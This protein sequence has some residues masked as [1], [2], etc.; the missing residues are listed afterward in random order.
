MTKVIL[1][2]NKVLD[3]MAKTHAALSPKTAE[4]AAQVTDMVFV[5]ERIKEYRKIWDIIND[6]VFS[7]SLAIT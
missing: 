3:E 2:Y 4:R 6:K 7:T 5:N 1:R